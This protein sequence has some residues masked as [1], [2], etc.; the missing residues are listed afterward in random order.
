MN[1]QM[2]EKTSHPEWESG[3]PPDLLIDPKEL[4]ILGLSG[5][6]CKITMK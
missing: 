5:T 2:H 6:E 1:D 3:S 4:D